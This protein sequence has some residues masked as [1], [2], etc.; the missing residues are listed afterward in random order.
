MKKIDSLYMRDERGRIIPGQITPGCEWVVAGEGVPTR[1]YDG[2][3]C[4]VK[5]G[6]L[7]KRCEWKAENGPA[8]ASWRHWSFDPAKQS[9]HGWITVTDSPDDTWHREAF[10]SGVDSAGD[11]LVDGMTY[12]LCGPKVQKNPERFDTHVLVL[13]GADVIDEDPRTYDELKDYLSRHD[14]EG[15]V[16]W[17]PRTETQ[18]KIKARDFGIL[19]GKKS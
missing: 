8:P 15:I 7:Y 4:L 14:I 18:C 12:E 5:G 9:G 11:P 2:T 16:W 13:H 17:N 10:A 6:V 3:C 19:R 1:K